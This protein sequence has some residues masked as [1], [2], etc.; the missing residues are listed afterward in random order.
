MARENAVET[1]QPANV[2]GLDRAAAAAN[3]FPLFRFMTRTKAA[4]D[5]KNIPLPDANGRSAALRS[6]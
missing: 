6:N 3:Q 2:A 1:N 5:A 4:N